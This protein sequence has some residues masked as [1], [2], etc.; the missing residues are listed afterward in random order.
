MKNKQLVGCQRG[1]GQGRK[2]IVREIKRYNPVTKYMSHEYEM[3]T[4]VIIVNNYAI[5]L[6]GD[7]W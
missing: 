6:Y 5:S 3:Y 1:R 4:V 7:I 2:E